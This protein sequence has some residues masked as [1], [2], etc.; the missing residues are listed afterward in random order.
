[1][2][3]EITKAQPLFDKNGRLS[4]PGWSRDLLLA[5]DRRDIRA[6]R[7]RIKEWDYYYAGDGHRAVCLTIADLAY[8]GLVTVT[9][10]DLD[11]RTE[12]SVT[13]MPILPMGKLG[14]SSTSHRGNVHFSDKRITISFARHETGRELTCYVKDFIGGQPLEV[15]LS[16]SQPE[17]D[18]MVIATPW[19]EDP[20]AF[21][22][23]QKINCMPVTGF[24]S[25]G[26]Q[27]YRFD[28]NHTFSTLDWGRGVWTYDNTWYWG[29]GN[30]MVDGPQGRGP[31][32]FNIGYGF[33]DTTAA[34]ENMIFYNYRAHK[35]GRLTFEI[36]KEGH[37]V[38][39]RPWKFVSDDGR[40]DMQMEPVFDRRAYTKLGPIL[41][42][43]H[44]VFGKFCGRVALDD[45]SEIHFTDVWGFAEEIHN[46]Y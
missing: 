3:N 40:L 31:F 43:G 44:Q 35:L 13:S 12:R 26:Q 23:N 39:G 46:K 33:G 5:Y 14:L 32:G 25:I 15:K 42:D 21:Y 34:S 41:N 20:K 10:I 11:Q 37:C 2:Q 38:E 27:V 22:Y 9:V 7:F 18:T 1:M 29:S 19:K 45:G 17:M 28:P 6:S 4:N 16:L 8:A 24:Y 36:P 30:G